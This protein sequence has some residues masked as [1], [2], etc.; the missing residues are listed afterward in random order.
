MNNDRQPAN[1]QPQIILI[2]GNMAAG[3]S[4]VAQSLAE[5]LP[6]SVHLRGDIFRRAIVNGQAEM[7]L[8]LSAEAYQQ[9]ELRYRLAAMV[10]RQ[11]LQAGFTVVYQDIIIGPTLAE[12]VAS[13]YDVFLSVIVL[14]PRAEVVAARDAARS[15]TGYANQAIV[16]AFD[17]ILRTETPHIGYWLDSS[18]LTVEETVD[19]ILANL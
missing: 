16:D 13:F 7:T 9:L 14:C 1:R 15:K 10:A 3:K 5:R 6:K 19:R 4:T 11:Y 12:V 2:T 8:N 18:N 17:R